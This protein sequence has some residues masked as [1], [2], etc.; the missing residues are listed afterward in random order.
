M[1]MEDIPYQVKILANYALL[2][3]ISVQTNDDFFLTIFV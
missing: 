3:A 2:Y 1:C